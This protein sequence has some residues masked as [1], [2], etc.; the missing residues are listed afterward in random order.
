MSQNVY[1]DPYEGGQAVYPIHHEVLIKGEHLDVGLGWCQA[2]SAESAVSTVRHN[3]EASFG[4]DAV[5]I[6]RSTS[7]DESGREVNEQEN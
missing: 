5:L 7:V 3:L 6:V 2:E 1:P 4:K